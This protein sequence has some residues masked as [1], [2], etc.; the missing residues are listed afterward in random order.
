MTTPYRIAQ[1]IEEMDQN[2]GLAD[3]LRQRILGQEVT[4]AIQSMLNSNV[5][6]MRRQ[7]ELGETVRDAMKAVADSVQK[8]ADVAQGMSLDIGKLEDRTQRTESE[9]QE[10]RKRTEE[11]G[12]AAQRSP[13]CC[14]QCCRAH[15]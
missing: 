14:R 6:M 3:A 7:A 11:N 1:I 13:R 15:L 2:P 8:M 10:A 12:R 5:E 9:V 4:T